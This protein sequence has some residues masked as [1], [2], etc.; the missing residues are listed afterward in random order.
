[1]RYASACSYLA[2]RSESFDARDLARLQV[3]DLHY[4]GEVARFAQRSREPLLEGFAFGVRCLAEADVV[5]RLFAFFPHAD[6][7]QAAAAGAADLP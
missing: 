4:P 6:L 2:M 7:K 3:G 1:M 5:E